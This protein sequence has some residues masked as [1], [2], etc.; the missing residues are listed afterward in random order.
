MIGMNC[1]GNAPA[2]QAY[3]VAMV[4]CSSLASSGPAR[5]IGTGRA[6][7]NR[8]TVP[9]DNAGQQTGRP[10]RSATHLSAEVCRQ[11]WNKHPEQQ[12]R[13]QCQTVY[14]T[15]GDQAWCPSRGDLVTATHAVIRDDSAHACAADFH[16]LPGGQPQ[17][18]L[19][20]DHRHNVNSKTWGAD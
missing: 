20:H 7:V 17:R 14:V 16:H 18:L 8:R 1:N 9:A 4:T 5:A 6:P 3:R 13:R 11:D 12:R 15:N 10:M 2:Q 19:S